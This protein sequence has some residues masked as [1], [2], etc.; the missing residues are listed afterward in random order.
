MV[1]VLQCMAS[2]LLWK[3]ILDKNVDETVI[4]GTACRFA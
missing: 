1:I 4:K 3:R 2:V